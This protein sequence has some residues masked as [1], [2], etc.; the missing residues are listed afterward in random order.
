MGGTWPAEA[1]EH[2]TL[3][4]Q[5]RELMDPGDPAFSLRHFLPL[6]LGHSPLPL[7]SPTTWAA[8][9]YFLCCFFFIASPA[10]KF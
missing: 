4:Q 2:P 10:S 1:P 6:A 3:A 7:D 8:F 5:T 9:S